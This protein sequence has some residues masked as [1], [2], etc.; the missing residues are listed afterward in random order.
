MVLLCISGNQVEWAEQ[1]EGCG[2]IGTVLEGLGGGWQCGLE[3]TSAFLA[4]GCRRA[5]VCGAHGSP[6]ATAG[7]APCTHQDHASAPCS[8]SAQPKTSG[9]ASY[10]HGKAWLEPPFPASVP[11]ALPGTHSG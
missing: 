7:S 8:S 11:L 3:S 1:E 9:P 5:P 2:G 6:V 4:A 10:I